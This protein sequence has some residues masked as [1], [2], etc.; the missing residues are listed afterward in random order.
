MAAASTPALLGKA[1]RPFRCGS[2]LA[3]RQLTQLHLGR[4][5]GAGV[6]PSPDMDF[7]HVPPK[8]PACLAF[9]FFCWA[10]RSALQ[11]ASAVASLAYLK[12][13]DSSLMTTTSL[14][15]EAVVVVAGTGGK[16]LTLA[17]REGVTF[18]VPPIAEL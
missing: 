14:T 18:G 7:T 13:P 11:Q 6:C 2:R 5:C 16:V 12:L 3:F 10:A 1:R 8:A 17:F 9:S 4:R 15:S